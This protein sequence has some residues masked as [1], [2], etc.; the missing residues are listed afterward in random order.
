MQLPAMLQ[1][2]AWLRRLTLL[3]ELRNDAKLLSLNTKAQY[4]SQQFTAHN[5]V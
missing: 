5:F 2:L 1:A 4:P 3:K